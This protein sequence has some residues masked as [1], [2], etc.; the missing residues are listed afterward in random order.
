[1]FVDGERKALAA[2]LFSVGQKIVDCERMLRQEGFSAFEF[3]QNMVKSFADD[4]DELRD[5]EVFKAE[6]AAEAMS[7]FGLS[8]SNARYVGPRSVHLENLRRSCGDECIGLPCRLTRFSSAHPKKYLEMVNL[9]NANCRAQI[10]NESSRFLDLADGYDIRIPSDR[11][12][13][14]KDGF[15]RLGAESA[16]GRSFSDPRPVFAFDM[17][18]GYSLTARLPK[19]SM[20]TAPA[21]TEPEFGLRLF[22]V[23][24]GAKA[25]VRNSYV[26]RDQYLEIKPGLFG[27]F[28][29]G[30]CTS[31]EEVC[32]TGTV[33][34]LVAR[35]IRDEFMLLQ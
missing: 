5:Y 32:C 30:S 23:Q 17:G 35:W 13:A 33:Y 8:P 24:D 22:V 10:R 26:S 6:S 25:A 18:D 11:V 14:A 12:A 20:F 2:R 9:S 1:V 27:L 15:S 31:L 34:G 16:A 7:S 19:T 4:E 28:A 21:V 3:P 29:Y